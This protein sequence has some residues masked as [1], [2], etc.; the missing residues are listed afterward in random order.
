MNERLSTLPTLPYKYDAGPCSLSTIMD[1]PVETNCQRAVQLF[2]A[3]VFDVFLP[4][5]A[6]LSYEGYWYFGRTIYDYPSRVDHCLLGDVIYGKSR[7][8]S[9]RGQMPEPAYNYHLGVI[10]PDLLPE[11]V[12]YHAVPKQG[13]TWWSWE[14]FTQKYEPIRIKRFLK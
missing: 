10:V 12:I 4:P 13:C 8:I 9:G 1:E 3:H 11:P 14:M 7:K 2:Y 6:C 5:Q